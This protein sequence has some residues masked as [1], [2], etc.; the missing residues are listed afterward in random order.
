MQLWFQ[1]YFLTKVN[2]TLS[3]L[4][5][6]IRHKL[7]KSTWF[8]FPLPVTFVAHF[9]RDTFFTSFSTWQINHNPQLAR[10]AFSPASHYEEMFESQQETRPTTC[11]HSRFHFDIIG[12]WCGFTS[13]PRAYPRKRKAGRSSFSS[14]VSCCCCCCSDCPTSRIKTMSCNFRPIV[15]VGLG[16][17]IAAFVETLDGSNH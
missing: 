11:M 4:R 13:F 10:A 8:A 6:R 3:F 2:E 5:N 7:Q 16:S 17:K 14:P 1:F 9:N 15:N 12:Q